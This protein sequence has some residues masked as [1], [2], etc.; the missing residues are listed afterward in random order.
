MLLGL[1]QIPQGIGI[2]AADRRSRIGRSSSAGADIDGNGSGATATASAKNVAFI[3]TSSPK[4]MSWRSRDR[5]PGIAPCRVIGLTG[6]REN[7]AGKRRRKTPVEKIPVRFPRR[8]CIAA[9]RYLLFRPGAFR[10]TAYAAARRQRHPIETTRIPADAPRRPGT[11]GM[12]SPVRPR[13]AASLILLRAGASGPEALLGRRSRTAR[14]MPGIFVFPGGAVQRSD[15]A[16]WPG[17][18]LPNGDA[19]QSRLR[20]SAR[21]ALRE[22]FEETGFIVGRP[23]EPDTASGGSDI[24]IAYRDARRI[25]AFDAFVPVGRAITPTRSPIRFDAQFF[26][27]DGGLALGPLH[28]GDELD[29]VGWYTVGDVSPTPMSGVTQFMLQHALAVWRGTA[30]GTPLYRHIG[31]RAKIEWQPDDTSPTR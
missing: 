2:A 28:S 18:I 22:T 13:R 24:D 30:T 12:T 6:P 3:E 27:A 17:E 29:E 16:P 19:G 26:L 5:T 11:S 10:T 8:G 14:F 15:A 7:A 23:A 31:I 20:I 25:P 9:L 21:A 4:G 1:E